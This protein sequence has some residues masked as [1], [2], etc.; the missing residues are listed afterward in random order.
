MIPR[1]LQVAEVQL[2][3]K[4]MPRVRMRP[5]VLRERRGLS[6]YQAGGMCLFRVKAENGFQSYLF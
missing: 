6:G 4:W 1:S 2:E 5:T 3:H